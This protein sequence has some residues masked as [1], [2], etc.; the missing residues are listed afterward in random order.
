MCFGWKP[1]AR[2]PE[3]VGER[4]RI[5]RFLEQVAR[6]A[7][8]RRWIQMGG[9][10]VGVIAGMGAWFEWSVLAGLAVCA[11]SMGVAGIWTRWC[12]EVLRTGAL[13]WSHRDR[14]VIEIELLGGGRTWRRDLRRVAAV[15]SG[16][17]DDG[18]RSLEVT[19]VTAVFPVRWLKA[20][21]FD[22]RGCNPWTRGVYRMVYG[23]QWG[24]WVLVAKAGRQ[25]PPRFRQRPCVKASHRMGAWMDVVT[26]LAEGLR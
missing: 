2:R 22:I 9:V 7:P 16:V 3:R 12:G 23:A 5:E 25:G 18:W 6:K 19:M 14:G 17:A 4:R 21:G 10:S 11:F 26:G 1:N 15:S 13:Q 24:L 20:W 8:R